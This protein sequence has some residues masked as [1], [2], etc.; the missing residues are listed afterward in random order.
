M[1]ADSVD[2]FQDRFQDFSFVSSAPLNWV[3][4][5]I[6]S[7][8][9]NLKRYTGN[10][11]ETKTKNQ[12]TLIDRNLLVGTVLKLF[13]RLVTKRCICCFFKYFRWFRKRNGVKGHNRADKSQLV[14]D[15]NPSISSVK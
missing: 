9:H 12:V 8:K 15:D 14:R 1:V 11:L 2:L 5:K 13:T 4:M 7:T 3:F 6:I 10:K